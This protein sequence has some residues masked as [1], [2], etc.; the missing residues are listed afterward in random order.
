MD[1][2]HWTVDDTLT[3]DENYSIAPFHLDHGMYIF[4]DG[5]EVEVAI[6]PR[7]AVDSRKAMIIGARCRIVPPRYNDG[8]TGRGKRVSATP[9]RCELERH[10]PT[11]EER[12]R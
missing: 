5:R 10:L 9:L 1:I 4:P 3:R 8:S 12:P 11:V 6:C 2:K 7:A